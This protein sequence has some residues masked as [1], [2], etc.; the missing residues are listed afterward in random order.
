MD[1]TIQVAI[2]TATVTFF[3]ALITAWISYFHE[4]SEKE[5]WERT[6]ELEKQKFKNEELKW[7]LELNNLREIE[8][9]KTRLRTYPE[10]FG[11]LAKLSSYNLN[12]FDEKLARELADK[13]TEWG[14]SEAGL[15][16]LD[17]TRDALFTLRQI[18]IR[19]LYTNI[20][21]EVAIEELSG[22]KS[23]RIDLIEFL[24]RDLNHGRSKWRKNKSLLEKDREELVKLSS[25]SDRNAD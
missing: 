23:K 12:Q 11:A 22:T 21:K 1:V 8:L 14:Y 9:H 17:E 20:S 18:L 19:F 16:M 25:S 4:R 3:A 6:L 10:V 24:R 13:F 5:K 2:I 7:I 15:C